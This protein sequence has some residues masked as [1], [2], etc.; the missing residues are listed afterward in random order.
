[1]NYRMIARVLGLILLCT[2]ALMLLPLGIALAKGEDTAG[3]FVLTILLLAADPDKTQDDRPF[4][5]GRLC[6]R[7]VGLDHDIPAGCAALCDQRQ[8]TQLY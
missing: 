6:D 1:M 4:R 8:H 2:A 5:K 3:A 7:G